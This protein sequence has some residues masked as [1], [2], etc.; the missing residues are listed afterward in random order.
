M[1]PLIAL[2]PAAVTAVIGAATVA[3]A[4]DKI[5]ESAESNNAKSE[6]I[7]KK[8]QKKYEAAS[9]EYNYNRREASVALSNYNQHRLNTVENTLNEY[10]KIVQRIKPTKLEVESAQDSFNDDVRE[11][12]IGNIK[13]LV[14]NIC[15]LKNQE[16][17]VISRYFDAKKHL[18]QARTEEAK[19]NQY[20]EEA[21]A[22]STLLSAIAFT[23]SEYDRLLCDL[24]RRLAYLNSILQELIRRSKL[25][26]PESGLIILSENEHKLICFPARQ[27]ASSI[28]AI[29]QYRILDDGCKLIKPDD[30]IEQASQLSEAD[31]LEQLDVSELNLP[32]YVIEQAE[33]SAKTALD[34]ASLRYEK[35]F[36]HAWAA[37]GVILGVIAGIVSCEMFDF[38]LGLI[39]GA[40]VYF[41]IVRKPVGED[42][43]LI[44]MYGMASV[45]L[46]LGFCI[47]FEDKAFR[48]D[49]WEGAGIGFLSLIGCG[50]VG[51]RQL[52]NLR[53]AIGF[54]AMSIFMVVLANTLFDFLYDW[55][56]F[57]RDV[58]TWICLI[59][60]FIF[61]AVMPFSDMDEA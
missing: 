24:S 39:V 14:N 15:Q 11:V 16:R 51:V 48:F 3:V 53:F 42:K 12:D 55:L 22:A 54:L 32:K 33:L 50:L 10:K 44:T 57:S 23:A 34:E 13:Q 25:R 58:S 35:R 20:V 47:F 37:L 27:L 8:A 19:V 2:I 7:L 5:S 43:L 30:S 59:L 36:G 41:A 9:K 52:R 28:K 61:L 45:S 21:R 29:V 6:K 40:L 46:A 26:D 18:E 49:F 38:P 17:N 4:K 60:L 31:Y 1:F 56:D